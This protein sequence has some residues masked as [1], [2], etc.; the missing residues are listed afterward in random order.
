MMTLDEAISHCKEVQERDDLCTSCKEEH[1]QLAD[2][3]EDYK[4]LKERATPKKPNQTVYNAFCP[5]CKQALG[6]QFAIDAI[7][8]IMCRQYCPNCGQALDWSD[9]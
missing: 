5:N 7:Q 1:Q 2:W 6:R 8:G 9:E 4:V 3:L